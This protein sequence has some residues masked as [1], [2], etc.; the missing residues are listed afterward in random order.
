MRWWL[1]VAEAICPWTRPTRDRQRQHTMVATSHHA[2]EGDEVS[3]PGRH[4]DDEA[5]RAPAASWLLGVGAMLP[6]VAGSA[7]IPAAGIWTDWLTR[8]VIIW[9]GAV[10]CFLGGVRRGLSFRQLGGATLGEV[11]AS[12]WLFACGFASIALPWSVPSLVV[13][14]VGYASA[15]IFDSAAGRRAEAPR[16]FSY[17]RPWQ[18]LL[19]ILSM[20][21]LITYFERP[22]G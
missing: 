15:A 7:S 18:M 19:P 6:I 1:Q 10:L 8:I 22:P 13:S 5:S 11:G 4:R 16:Y 17:F 14:A 3:A 12:L 9:E 20:L 2:K 21:F